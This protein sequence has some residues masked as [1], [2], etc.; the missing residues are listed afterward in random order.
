MKKRF[1][2]VL[3]LAL[4]VLL[5]LAAASASTHYSVSSSSPLKV[6]RLPDTGSEVLASYRRDFALT[7]KKNYNSDWAYVYFTDG[8]E[9][10]V[11]RKY[12]K[13]T[14]SFSAWITTDFS[15]LR[16]GPYSSYD[17]V[18]SL[19]RGTKVTVYTSGSNWNYVTCSA[20]SGYIKKS[21]LSKKKIALSANGYTPYTAYVIK[22]TSGKV[23]Y[24]R[25]AGKGYAI[26]GYLAVGTPV[27]VTRVE[28]NW[29]KVIVNET[30]DTGYIQ[31]AN[32]SKSAPKVTEGPSPAPDY[33]TPT[34]EITG[35]TMYIISSNGKSVNL[36]KSAGA[37]GQILAQLP[38][39]TAV[40]AL[41]AVKD[42]TRVTVDD[43]TTGYVMTKFLSSVRQD[44]PEVTPAPTY[45]IGPATVFSSDGYSTI[46][47]H[48]G[49]GLG[50]ANV[51][52]VPVGA[53]VT[54]LSVSDNGKWTK[55]LYDGKTGWIMSKFL[56]Y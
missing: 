9:G 47:M 32:L 10:Y 45:P 34:P 40:T 46:N 11:Q 25:G 30:G 23:P 17:S 12:L 19:P 20:G 15:D 43:G 14:S 42:W 35:T 8:H 24:Y 28:T 48:R 4:A 39:G 3:L 49:P 13:S 52:R 18:A 55:I 56:S 33:A 37:S 26:S 36:R 21:L 5:P 41:N 29:T 51:T 1:V 38:F 31:N 53:T 7:S 54:V 6:Y 22:S 50:Y 16:T 27:T 44:P 2:F